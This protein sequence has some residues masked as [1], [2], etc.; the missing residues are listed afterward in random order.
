M[1]YSRLSIPRSIKVTSKKCNDDIIGSFEKIF[2]IIIFSFMGIRNKNKP[3]VNKYVIE[4][5]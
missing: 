1:I 5:I 2:M 4:I 3:I